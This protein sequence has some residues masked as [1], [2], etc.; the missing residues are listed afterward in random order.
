MEEP[1]YKNSA[2]L[3][4]TP[5]LPVEKP[6]WNKFIFI[7]IIFL[8]LGAGL[9]GAATYLG[10]TR[11]FMTDGQCSEIVYNAT[12]YGY[13]VALFGVLNETL[14]CEGVVPITF[15]NETYD[16]VAVRCLQGVQNG[17]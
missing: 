11:G 4:S 10:Q 15:G 12:L 7:A 8:V 14:K 5:S 16:I 9:F 6:N 17:G 3:P 1:L 2:P 13:N